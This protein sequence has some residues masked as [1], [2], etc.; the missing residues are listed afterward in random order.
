MNNPAQSMTVQD[1]IANKEKDTAI[2]YLWAHRDTLDPTFLAITQRIATQMLPYGDLC[3]ETQVTQGTT[4]EYDRHYLFACM[5]RKEG[6]VEYSTASYSERNED[7]NTTPTTS[8]RRCHK[9]SWWTRRNGTSAQDTLRPLRLH[10]YCVLGNRGLA[11]RLA[12]TAEEV[13]A[14]A[15]GDKHRAAIWLHHTLRELVRIP[16]LRLTAKEWINGNQHTLKSTGIPGKHLA[17]RWAIIHASRPMMFHWMTLY[18]PW[19]QYSRLAN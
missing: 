18:L 11:L 19:W 14:A 2:R 4:R 17:E 13:I 16:G 15:E 1:R 3:F 8:S 12:D 7:T 5:T 6:V 10:E 9:G